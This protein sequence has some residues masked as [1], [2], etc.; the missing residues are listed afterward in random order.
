MAAARLP[1]EVVEL[2]AARAG[3]WELWAGPR[4]DA[5]LSERAAGAVVLKGVFRVLRGQISFAN[6]WF[7]LASW[8]ARA[9]FSTPLQR[10]LGKMIYIDRNA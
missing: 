8:L 10:F 5:S 2:L 3:F 9:S 1:Q 7:V 4:D 6:S